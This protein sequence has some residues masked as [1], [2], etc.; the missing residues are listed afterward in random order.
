MTSP[1]NSVLHSVALEARDDGLETRTIMG[2]RLGLEVGGEGIIGRGIS[3]VRRGE[4]V[5]VGIVGWQ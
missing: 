5:G 4:I 2:K 3:V 1:E